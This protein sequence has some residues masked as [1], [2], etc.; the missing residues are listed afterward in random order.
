MAIP[1]FPLNLGGKKINKLRTC[2]LYNI[3]HS[4]AN[5]QKNGVFGEPFKIKGV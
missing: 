2:L 4:N 5:P 3:R 1:N